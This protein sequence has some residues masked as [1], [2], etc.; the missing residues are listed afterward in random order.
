MIKEHS[1]NEN[2]IIALGQVAG[3]C[4]KLCKKSKL[5]W[6]VVS[7]LLYRYCFDSFNSFKPLYNEALQIGLIKQQQLD[8][9]YDYDKIMEENLG[10]M[11]KSFQK[12]LNIPDIYK[13]IIESR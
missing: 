12:K 9:H 8:K 3:Y 5:Q 4:S 10:K 13:E 1:N 2:L 7:L 11:Y 6:K